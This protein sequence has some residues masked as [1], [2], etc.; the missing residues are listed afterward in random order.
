LRATIESLISVLVE[1]DE[2][3]VSGR[4]DRFTYER[5]HDELVRAAGW[6][7]EELD[8]EI[9]RRWD[10]ITSRSSRAPDVGEA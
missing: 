6:T 10:W 9:D 7:P 2:D 8:A 5:E 4:L 1:L 3:L